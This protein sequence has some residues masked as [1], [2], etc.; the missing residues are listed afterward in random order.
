M[1]MDMNIGMEQGLTSDSVLKSH[2]SF[3]PQAEPTNTIQRA[4]MPLSH[5]S[6]SVDNQKKSKNKVIWA[7]GRE[8]S[9]GSVIV[10]QGVR[11]LNE[12]RK[13]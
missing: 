13:I 9:P 2:D 5:A 12:K 7:T 8:P 3:L 1:P 4:I 10:G 11:A 6:M